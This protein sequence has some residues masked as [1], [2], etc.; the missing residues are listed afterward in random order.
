MVRTV[1]VIHPD[2]DRIWPF[3]ADR[4]LELWQSPKPPEV[5]RLDK[6]DDC[7]AGEVIPSPST[8]TRLVALHV[9]IT[10]SCLE[11][12]SGLREIAIYPTLPE[13]VTAA[14]DCS[15][16]RQY[17]HASEGYWAQSVAEFAL[18][19][20]LCGLRRIPQLHQEI[21][22]SK[23][24]W[25]YSIRAL[26]DRVRTPGKQ[27]ADDPRFTNGTIEGKR[28][29]I[30]GAGNIGSRY[31]S[32]VHMMGADVAAWD[33]F[34]AEPNFHRAG[35]RKIWHL[36][37][38]LFD[39]E[40]FVPMVPLTETT[41][42]LVTA[43]HINS[44]PRGCLVVLAT[45]ARI[46][47]VEALRTRVQNDE[48]SLAA[49]VFDVEPLPLDDALLGRHNVV[50]TPHLAGRTADSNRSWVDALVDQFDPPLYQEN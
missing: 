37:Q 20:T 48:L 6:G 40:I 22:S 28:I 42:G 14:L 21:Q 2:F 35:A 4:F 30:V 13:E 1:I 10:T 46:C 18:A 45:R 44:L 33:P 41:E 39:A 36:E 43:D 19:L 50:H 3:A 27:F 47:D 7:S 8:V 23:K 34:A 31:A 49:D 25:D 17:R 24:P 38:L 29:R 12:L 26:N 9:P 11:R 15:G 16:V 5:I 32:F